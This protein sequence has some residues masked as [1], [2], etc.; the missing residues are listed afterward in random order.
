MVILP[1]IDLIGGVCVR[2]T[3]GNYATSAK[4]A[5]DPVETAKSFEAQGAK[6]LHMVDLDGAKAGE[7]INAEV[8]YRVR[9]ATAL[10]IEVGGGI[11]TLAAVERYLGA[12]IDRVIFGSAAIKDPSLVR[13]AV[14][15]FGNVIAVG[16][17]AKDG[18]V[19]SGGWLE[20]S[21]TDFL[22]LAA[23]MDA[24]GVPTIIYTDI[25]K[26]G[27]LAGPNLDELDRVNGKVAADVIASGGIR[28]IGDIRALMRLGVSGAICGKS[29][30]EGTLDLAAA[31]RLA[32]E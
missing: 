9:A 4:V 6:W 19:R 31:V 8:A 3:Q 25:A 17:D 7:P 30:Y 12:G 5:D 13:E 28:D 15:K 23:A 32:E 22:D 21:E 20:D 10:R 1:A 26:D 24:A 29:I 2:L 16:I 11:R 14:S 18:R 27:T